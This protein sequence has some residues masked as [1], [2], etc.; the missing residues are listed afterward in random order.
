[1]YGQNTLGENNYF[2]TGLIEINKNSNLDIILS[3]SDIKKYKDIF[4]IQKDGKWG[5]AEK[6]INTLENK[7][8]M[9]HVKY[10]KLMHP[11]KYRSPYNELK[12]WLDL[13]NDHPMAERIWKLAKMRKPNNVKAPKSPKILSR[14]S[15]YGMDRSTNMPLKKFKISKRYYKIYSNIRSLVK[16]GRPTSALKQLNSYNNLPQNIYDDLRGI[17]ATGY[18]SVGKDKTSLKLSINSAARSGENNPILYWR[19]ALAA[20]RLNEQDVALKNFLVLS[21]IKDDHWLKSAGAYWASKIYEDMNNNKESK[22]YLNIASKHIDTFYGQLAMERLQIDSNINWYLKNPGNVFVLDIFDNLHL[23]RAIALSMTGR[24]GEAD[25][26]IRLLY[27]YLGDNSLEEL[28]ELADNLNL[29]AVQIRLGDKLSQKENKEYMALYPSPNWIDKENLFVDEAFLWALIRKESSFYLKAKS[30]RGA[31]GLMQLMP[32]TARMVARDRS[33]R[34]ANKWQ[35]Y[36]LNKNLEIG[37]KLIERLLNLEDISNSIIPLLIA[38]NAGP[39]RLEQWNKKIDK[40]KDPLLYIESIPSYE[41]RWF[42]KK[43]LK[44]LWIY[45]DKFKQIK[46]TRKALSLNEWPKYINLNFVE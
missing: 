32:S 43:V 34:G 24:Y 7:I 22:K 6:I 30:N 41:T 10:Q 5:E 2:Y 15:G 20:Y 21:K 28:I 8:L 17:I 18:F 26:E 37:Q 42:V 45:R 14:I 33:I 36:D 29:P 46:Y 9:G 39:N 19:S 1:V 38:W 27:G 25:Q 44:N 3:D 4:A 16:R 11:T 23:K 35:L 31:R 13:Y 12:D 40:Y